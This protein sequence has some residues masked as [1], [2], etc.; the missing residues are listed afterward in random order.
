MS[1]T[2]FTFDQLAAICKAFRAQHPDDYDAVLAALPST[3]FTIAID[4][5]AA[6]QASECTAVPCSHCGGCS[7]CM[8][9]PR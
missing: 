5:N 4:W 3:P 2:P 9:F 7:V 8:G 6:Q 1:G